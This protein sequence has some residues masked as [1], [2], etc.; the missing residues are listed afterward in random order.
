MGDM[1]A[2]EQERWPEIDTEA[3]QV[4][5]MRV[6]CGDAGRGAQS[7]IRMRML[8]RRRRGSRLVVDHIP[9]AAVGLSLVQRGV[10]A[11]TK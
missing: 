10:G 5:F 7:A 4:G 6:R 3:E 1:D 11:S 2:G 9:V 8:H